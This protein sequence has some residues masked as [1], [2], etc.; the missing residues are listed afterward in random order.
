MVDRTSALSNF[1]S[2]FDARFAESSSSSSDEKELLRLLESYI[3]NW[4]FISCSL[5]HRSVEQSQQLELDDQEEQENEDLEV[6]EIKD[7]RFLNGTMYYNVSWKD[8]QEDDD[9][10]VRTGIVSTLSL[11]QFL[12]HTLFLSLLCSV[13]RLGCVFA[14]FLLLPLSVAMRYVRQTGV[15]NL[16]VCHHG[17][18]SRNKRIVLLCV[19]TFKRNVPRTCRDGAAWLAPRET[20]S[21]ASHAC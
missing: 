19:V 16:N 11:A 18:I 15:C 20:I 10:W 21:C 9:T 14:F 7:G 17:C 5:C 3:Q 12:P 2:L 13:N 8:C 1:S 6:S 4:G